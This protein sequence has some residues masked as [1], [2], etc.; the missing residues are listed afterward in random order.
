MEYMCLF[1]KSQK[2][3]STSSSTFSDASMN[4]RSRI[5]S[6]K[7]SSGA[8]TS[9][10]SLQGKNNMNIGAKTERESCNVQ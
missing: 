6:T 9:C 3:S 4:T 10:T 5:A 7:L 8:R 1:Y 2:I